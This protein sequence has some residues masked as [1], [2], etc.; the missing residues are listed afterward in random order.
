M[1]KEWIEVWDGE[2]YLLI[3]INNISVIKT[4][5]GKTRIIMNNGDVYTVEIDK[6]QVYDQMNK[7]RRCGI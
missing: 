6:S 4:I 1:L 5:E 3:N 2:Q 7:A